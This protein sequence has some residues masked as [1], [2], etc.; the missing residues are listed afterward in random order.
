M[1]YSVP[2]TVRAQLF[3]LLRIFHKTETFGRLVAEMVR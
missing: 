2:K 1:S 3:G